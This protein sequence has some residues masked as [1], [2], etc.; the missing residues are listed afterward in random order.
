M[1]YE[2]ESGYIFSFIILFRMSLTEEQRMRIEK[3]RQNALA[4]RASRQQSVQASS[5]PSCAS[6]NAVGT[7]LLPPVSSS[8]LSNDWQC[9]E[10]PKKNTVV[11]QKLAQ[12][13]SAFE[14]FSAG[15][16]SKSFS[17][18]ISHSKS[19]LSNGDSTVNSRKV[20]GMFGGSGTKAVKCI[21]SSRRRFMIDMCYFPPLIEVFKS[22]ST[23]QYGKQHFPWL[24]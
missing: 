3:S 8:K 9:C 21:L 23:R 5:V 12:N 4:L 11:P 10:L 6:G 19:G 2:A 20:N 18:S 13:K 17:K 24:I 22:M 14:Q 7:K 1:I 15:I 16:H